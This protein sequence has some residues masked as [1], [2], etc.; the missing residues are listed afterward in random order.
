MG[1]KLNDTTFP[2]FSKAFM[3]KYKK[4]RAKADEIANKILAILQGEPSTVALLA[5]G[6]TIAPLMHARMEV[7][8]AEASEGMDRMKAGVL[9]DLEMLGCK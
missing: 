2:K 7:G 4:D 6:L 3:E 5:V 1:Q 9:Q 8:L